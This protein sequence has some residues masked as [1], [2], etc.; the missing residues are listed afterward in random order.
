[1]DSGEEKI[2][3]GGLLP[4]RWRWPGFATEAV[5]TE[6][7]WGVRTYQSKSDKTGELSK[8]GNSMAMA[9]AKESMESQTC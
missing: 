8:C 6:G 9:S 7:Q 2:V 1:M 4:A 3:S 5:G